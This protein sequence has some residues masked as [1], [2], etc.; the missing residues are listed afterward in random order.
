MTAVHAPQALARD[1]LIPLGGVDRVPPGEWNRLARRGFHLHQWF[2]GAERSGWNPRHLAVHD[3][4]GLKTVVPAYL[5]GP[6]TPQDLHHR[7]LGRLG[8][9][10]AGAGLRL[11]PVLSVQSPFAA[12]SQPLGNSTALSSGILHEIFYALEQTAEREGAKAVAWPFIDATSDRL[13]DVATER[14]YRVL[15]SGFTAMARVRWASFDDYVASRSESVR[16]TILADIASIGAAGLRTTETSDFECDASHMDRLYRE[17][18]R[19]KHRRESPV[20][21]HFFQQLSRRQS[22]EIRAHLTWLGDRLVGS[23]LNLCTPER[24]DAAFAAFTPEHGGGGVFYNDQCY[25]PL[26]AAIRE[27]VSAVDLGPGAL[28]G[29]VL[30]GAVLQRRMILI[31]GSTPRRHRLLSLL[32]RLVARR[33]QREERR[34]LGQLWGP[35]CFHEDAV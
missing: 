3:G 32:G 26:R 21:A 5:V 25:E 18:Y 34:S 11:W 13:I 6:G 22:P 4:A 1:Q 15:Y 30:R 9:A 14:G 10:A 28:H 2:A 33:I 7:W 17:S 20:A 31:R 12:V 8:G 23:S 27:G 35:G 19:R 16:R 29:K 24:L